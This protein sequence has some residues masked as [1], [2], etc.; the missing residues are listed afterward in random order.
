MKSIISIFLTVLVILAF[1][2]CPSYVSDDKGNDTRDSDEI[3][4][5]NAAFQAQK[6]AY[7]EGLLAKKTA[8]SN[9]R[10]YI[11]TVDVTVDS[12]G[13]GGTLHIVGDVTG[14]N[15]I[16]MDFTLTFNNYCYQGV[17]LNGT[18]T[19]SFSGSAANFTITSTSTGDIIV[20][21]DVTGSFEWNL[22]TAFDESKFS[23]SGTVGGV[24]IS[25]DYGI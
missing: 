17:I 13:C 15:P 21:G 5:A 20:T 23:M 19:M 7:N 10:V 3:K 16:T 8:K 6:Q 4:I 22:T 18:A 9:T 25:I 1:I 12:V 24:S 2:A 14:V 11:P